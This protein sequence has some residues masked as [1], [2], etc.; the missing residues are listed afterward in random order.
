MNHGGEGGTT[1]IPSHVPL[2]PLLVGD[3]LDH[4]KI[5]VIEESSYPVSWETILK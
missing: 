5:R 4:P 3:Q 2:D 1:H